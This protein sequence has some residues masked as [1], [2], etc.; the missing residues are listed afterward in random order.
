MS[1]LLG[2]EGSGSRSGLVS[3]RKKPETT[4]FPQWCCGISLA[5][6]CTMATSHSR[7]RHSSK[8]TPAGPVCLLRWTFSKGAR[9]IT[10][11]IENDPRGSYD[12]CVVPH[13]DVSSAVVEVEQ[14]PIGAFR[15]HADIARRLRAAGWSLSRRAH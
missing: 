12:V 3:P 10:C 14:E 1:D 7:R 4:A 15:R 5:Q 13:W 2:F 8:G 9:S 6:Q 11:Q